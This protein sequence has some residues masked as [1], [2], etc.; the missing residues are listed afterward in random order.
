MAET[1]LVRRYGAMKLSFDGFPLVGSD[2]LRAHSGGVFRPQLDW[3][4]ISKIDFA[5]IDFAKSGRDPVGL[6]LA[7]NE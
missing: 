3:F 4:S 7:Q 2:G 5:Q 6:V 1:Q